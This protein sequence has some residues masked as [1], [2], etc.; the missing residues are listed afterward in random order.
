LIVLSD[1]RPQA[2]DPMAH[3]VAGF[4]WTLKSGRYDDLDGAALRIPARR[5]CRGHAIRRENG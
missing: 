4:L 2:V 3:G 1:E 5:R